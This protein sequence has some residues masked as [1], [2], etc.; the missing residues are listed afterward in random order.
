MAQ[1]ELTW[2]EFVDQYKPIRN[3]FS[4]DEDQQMYETFGA[5]LDFVTKANSNNVWT[6]LEGDG[7]TVVVE[8]YHYVNRLGYYITEIPWEE[9]NSYQVDLEPWAESCEDCGESETLDGEL[10]MDVFRCP[11]QKEYCL[12]CCGCPEHV[13]EDWY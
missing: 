6:Y 12:N 13:G 4:K 10:I 11:D 2:S 9:G 7:A 1:I 3:V 8:G 5:E